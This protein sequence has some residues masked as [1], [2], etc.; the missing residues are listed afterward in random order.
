MII[1]VLH[2]SLWFLICFITSGVAYDVARGRILYRV[3]DEEGSPVAGA[4]F[5]GSGWLPDESEVE[6]FGGKTDGDGMAQIDF[7]TATEISGEF[8]KTNYYRSDFHHEFGAHVGH[9]ISDG[10]WQPYPLRK[11]IVLKRIVNPIPMYVKRVNAAIPVMGQPVGYDL[12]KGDWVVPFGSGENGDILIS[13]TGTYG[14]VD[15]RYGP[16]VQSDLSMTVSFANTNDGVQILSVPVNRGSYLGSVLVSSHEAP[17]A[18]YVSEY[19]YRQVISPNRKERI[20]STTRKEQI[21]YLRVRTLATMAGDAIQSLYGKIY[22]DFQAFPYQEGKS[23]R[24]RFHY[25]LNPKPNDRNLEFDP[26][27][28]LMPHKGPKY[29]HPRFAP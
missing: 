26:E 25:Y 9:P 15:T 18:G 8:N 29:M 3:V 13:A 17:E 22:G 24:V 14:R 23:I 10:R 6:E 5:T 2:M 28:N 1:R 12:V 27:Q 19:H 20:N 16:Q 21:A 11:E 4:V 7:L